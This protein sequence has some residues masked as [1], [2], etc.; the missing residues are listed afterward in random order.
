ME[1]LSIVDENWNTLVSFFP[2]D[3]QG[4]GKQCG[5]MTRLRGFRSAEELMRTLL[6]HLGV[7]YSL[8]ETAVV[9]KT[10]GLADVSDV[11]LLKRLRCAE[12]WFRELCC[13]LVQESGLSIPSS[14]H[15][16]LVRLID[17]TIVKEPGKTGSQWRIHYSLQLPSLQ[18]DYLAVTSTKGN[19][20]GESLTQYPVRSQECLIGDRG[21]STAPGLAHVVASGGH[22][23]IRLNTGALLLYDHA[24]HR[25]NVFAAISHLHTAGDRQEWEIKVAKPDGGYIPGRL[26]A[27]RKSEHAIA[28]ALNRIKSAA[29]KK[30]RTVK[31]E[32]LECA[33]FVLVVTTISPSLFSF[34]E[35]LE[36]YRVRWQI[37]LVFKRLKSLAGLGHLPKWDE[38]SARAWLYGKLFVGLLT[39]KLV[40]HAEAIS[41]WG[42]DLAR[43]LSEK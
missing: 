16:L 37:E 3:W 27:I 30:Q 15:G 33:K 32:T 42:Y 1:T 40:R 38:E 35:I 41:P 34:E 24:E 2:K 29:S 21:Y 4:L 8:R 31:P 12:I 18:C 28:L 14:A 36:W 10:A 9:A 39:Q 20:T 22:A 6:L 13:R 7:G 5:A 17:G 26:C 43:D 11:A 23:I 19:Q 25:L